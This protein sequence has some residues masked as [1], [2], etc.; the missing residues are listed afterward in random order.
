[1]ASCD[2]TDDRYLAVNYHNTDNQILADYLNRTVF[3]V[4]R[5][6]NILKLRKSSN[7][8]KKETWS[9]SELNF[10]TENYGKLSVIEISKHLKRSRSCVFAKLE[11]LGLHIIKRHS[12]NGASSG[13]HFRNCL[14]A[15][16]SE[17]MAVFLK[18]LVDAKRVDAVS[19]KPANIDLIQLRESYRVKLG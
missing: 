7:R 16:Q 15:E 19:K 8:P 17:R 3:A 4:E 2:D 5:R 13:K 10:V 18:M 12:A 11:F 14:T 1:M 6:A 9:E